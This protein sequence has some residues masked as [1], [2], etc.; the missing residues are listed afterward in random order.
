MD[1]IF[2]SKK[3]LNLL[4]I[5]LLFYLA[6]CEI[7]IFNKRLHANTKPQASQQ[8]VFLYKQMGASYLCKSI[9]DK[10]DFDF[11]KA[12]A[13]STYTFAE[14]IF[15]KHGNLI[16]EAGKEKLTPEKVLYIGEIEILN[17][18]IKICPKQIPND[19]K[20]SFQ[21]TLKKLKKQTNKKR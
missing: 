7:N 13:V 14:V 21:E 6:I 17:S 8:D 1:T 11:N 5:S 12:L 19:V 3:F 16:Q 2:Q 9:N 4:N 10:I 15:S 18:A 20:K